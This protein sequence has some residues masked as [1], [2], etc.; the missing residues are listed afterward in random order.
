[1]TLMGL[2][3]AVVLPIFRSEIPPELPKTSESPLTEE[4]Y[5]QIKYYCAKAVGRTKQTVGYDSVV[6]DLFDNVM[7]KLMKNDFKLLREIHTE[8]PSKLWLKGVIAS[9]STDMLR[10]NR[11]RIAWKELGPYA[12]D[13]ND[14][15]R[16]YF[17]TIDQIIDYLQINKN[18]TMS[19]EEI[20]KL[21]NVIDSKYVVKHHP[22]WHVTEDDI[23]NEE[24]GMSETEF[25]STDMGADEA[26]AKQ[27]ITIIVRQF[28]EK[29][30]EDDRFLISAFYGSEDDE[31]T[32][33]EIA[34]ILNDSRSKQQ[35]KQESN[36]K[37]V[38]LP[39]REA[40]E[41]SLQ[42]RKG[43]IIKEFEGWLEKQKVSV[44]DLIMQQV[45]RRSS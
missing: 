32:L 36:P 28:L 27:E 8:K 34:A 38:N 45:A 12:K 16:N 26:V 6:D 31:M 22:D 24:T 18:V 20:S 33:K 10:S 29:L 42:K 15:S 1:M 43:R 44:N 7:K 37:V 14:L 17:F 3:M 19:H 30:S 11:G 35:L 5:D 25:M 4:L 40:T 9:V 23:Y 21:L 39:Q 2:C 41:T 13:I